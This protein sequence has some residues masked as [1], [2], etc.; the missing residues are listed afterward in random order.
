MAK[1]CTKNYNA[2]AQPL[3]LSLNLLFN[4]VAVAIMVFLSS[5][6]LWPYASL[7]NIRNDDDDDDDCISY[8]PI[9]NSSGY[10][11]FVPFFRNKFPGLFQD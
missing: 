7:G 3:F 8:G 11:G 4:D 9:N 2:H 6:L 5:L 1:K 10:A